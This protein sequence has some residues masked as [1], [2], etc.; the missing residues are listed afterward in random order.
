MLTFRKQ[1]ALIAITLLSTASASAT[2]LYSNVSL[3]PLMQRLTLTGLEGNASI[4][5]ADAMVSLLGNANG[6]V[7]G[8]VQ[9]KTGRDNGW[10]VGAGA[11]FEKC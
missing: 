3:T 9:G 7:Y 6:F 1:A 11:G 10:L 2:S 4:G 8:D 5:S